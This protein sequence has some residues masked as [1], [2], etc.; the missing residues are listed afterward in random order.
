[1]LTKGDVK[2]S[3]RHVSETSN[4]GIQFTLTY[5]PFCCNGVYLRFFFNLSNKKLSDAKD[6]TRK[7]GFFIVDFAMF[8]KFISH[9][10]CIDT[11]K[12][13]KNLH[14]HFPKAIIENG[15]LSGRVKNT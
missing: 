15:H 6:Y 13:E 12:T 10:T 9:F 5:F 14:F 4:V 7:R 2:L 8:F 11:G 1:M 3:H